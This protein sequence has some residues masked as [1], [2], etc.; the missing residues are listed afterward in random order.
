[1][2]LPKAY[3]KKYPGNLKKAWAAYKAD[4]GGKKSTQTKQST[5]SAGGNEMATH[6][7]K[8]GG[9]KHHA[10]K[11]YGFAKANPLQLLTSTAMAVAGGVASAMLI[12]RLPMLKDSKPMTKGAIQIGT[13]MLLLFV[14]KNRIAQALGG[15]AIVAG[16]FSLAKGAGFDGLAGSGGRSLTQAEMLQLGQNLANRSL[17]RPV[18][19]VGQLGRPVNYS[20]SLGSRVMPGLNTMPGWNQ[21]GWG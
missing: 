7:K 21:N 6:K 10:K 20:G 17:G 2:P 15:G 11:A 18:N 4:H 3:F 9:V 12:N 14:L 8:S 13:G 5:K 16:G 19:Y 1:M